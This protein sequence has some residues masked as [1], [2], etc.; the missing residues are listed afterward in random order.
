MGRRGRVFPVDPTKEGVGAMPRPGGDSGGDTPGDGRRRGEMMFAVRVGMQF[1]GRES[2]QRSHPPP[3][4]RE[5]AGRAGTRQRRA[6]T[7]RCHPLSHRTPSLRRVRSCPQ[8]HHPENFAKA[9][10]L[11]LRHLPKPSPAARRPCLC[12]RT[13]PSMENAPWVEGR[14]TVS[15]RGWPQSQGTLLVLLLCDGFSW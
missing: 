12:R 10:F 4:P 5:G 11:I 2:F 9:L 7:S 1:G 3:P 14:A 15:L 8:S 13:S 6:V